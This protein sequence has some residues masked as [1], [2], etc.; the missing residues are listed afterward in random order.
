MSKLLLRPPDGTNGFTFHQGCGKPHEYDG[1]HA[2]DCEPCVEHVRLM[3]PEERISQPDLRAP[4]VAV[5]DTADELD[6]M[7]RVEEAKRHAASWRLVE[8]SG[9]PDTE[10]DDPLADENAALRARIAELEAAA[11]PSAT[12]KAPAKA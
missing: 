3:S 12:R 11:K 6:V 1:E 7:R 9:D 2:I 10:S 8:A 5:G 4:L